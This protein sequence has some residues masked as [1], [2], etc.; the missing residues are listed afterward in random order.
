MI[1]GRCCRSFKLG[2]ADLCVTGT[3]NNRIEPRNYWASAC[4]CRRVEE[5]NGFGSAAVAAAAASVRMVIT[6]GS[7]DFVLALQCKLPN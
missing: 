2:H 1:G 6:E 7:K 4:C 3:R 5:V